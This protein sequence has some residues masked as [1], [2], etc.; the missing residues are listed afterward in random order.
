[1]FS[2]LTEAVLQENLFT[3]KNCSL[4]KKNESFQRLMS[5]N[6]RQ[7]RIELFFEF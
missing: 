5:S 4:W 3:E 7:G 1:M 6:Q 2:L